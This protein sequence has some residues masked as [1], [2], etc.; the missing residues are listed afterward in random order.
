[1][2]TPQQIIKTMQSARCSSIAYVENYISMK[3]INFFQVQK[4]FLFN[5][6]HR[7]SPWQ[8]PVSRNYWN[9]INGSKKTIKYHHELWILVF[10]RLFDLCLFGF[11]G[12]LFLLM[13]GKGCGLWLWHSLDFSLT[14]FFITCCLLLLKKTVLWKKKKKKKKKKKN[15]Q[16]AKIQL[17]PWIQPNRVVCSIYRYSGTKNKAYPDREYSSQGFPLVIN[18][19]KVYAQL[20]CLGILLRI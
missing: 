3:L 1:M 9:N 15:V 17:H 18:G 6:L 19:F 5:S 13:S 12:F 16:M 14:L 7:E 10:V 2:Y 20:R 4:M 8:L 11:V